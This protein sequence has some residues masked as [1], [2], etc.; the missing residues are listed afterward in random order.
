MA[1][2]DPDERA[3][4][5]HGLRSL[6]DYSLLLR[7]SR[8]RAR[9]IATDMLSHLAFLV[10]SLGV[11]MS[12]DPIA[13]P[14]QAIAAGVVIALV[15]AGWSILTRPALRSIANGVVHE[16]NKRLKGRVNLRFKARRDA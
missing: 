2:A 5:I 11:G 7:I 8:I 15:N 9:P 13:H 4:L 14:W 12:I 16:L 6:A 3:A 1:Y 10:V